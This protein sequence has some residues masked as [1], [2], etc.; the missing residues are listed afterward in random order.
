MRITAKVRASK[1]QVSIS[2]SDR[3]Y[4]P[5]FN[6]T[7]SFEDL[8]NEVEIDVTET[9]ETILRAYLTHEAFEA[10]VDNAAAVIEAEDIIFS[11]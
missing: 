9:V 1:A 3:N 10:A 2:F 4:G 5:N 7:Q 8:R 11:F 6:F